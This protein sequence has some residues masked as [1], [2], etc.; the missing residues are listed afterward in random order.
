MQNHHLTS[1]STSPKKTARQNFLVAEPISAIT[2]A[3]Q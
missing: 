3:T 1:V 2:Y